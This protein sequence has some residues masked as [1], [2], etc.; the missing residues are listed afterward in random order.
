MNII[1]V[2]AGRV[3]Y[4]V[5]EVLSSS[6][7]IM[8]VERDAAKAEVVKNQLNISVL[9]DDGA[10]PKVLRNA[11]SRHKADTV[12]ATTAADD[13]NL[14]IC[15]MCKRIDPGIKT[16]ARVRNPDY[17]IET[18]ADGKEGVDQLIKPELTSADKIA[19]LALLENAIDYESIE[20]LNLSIAIF[21]VTKHNPG[22]E[23]RVPLTLDIPANTGIVAIYRGDQVITDV[24]TTELHLGDRIFVLGDYGG[25]EA[26]NEMMGVRR[27][28]KEFVILG[29]GIT[30]AHV[31]GILESKKRYVKLIEPDP[32]RCKKLVRDFSSVIVVNG[33]IV[34]PH[35]LKNENIGRADAVIALSH[36]DETNLLACH[37]AI[38]LGSPK[39]IA[40]YS[41]MDYEDIFE[42]T[43]IRTVIGYHRVVANEITKTM[44]SD[45][46]SVLRMKNPEE[47][48]FTS[49][50]GMRSKLLGAR[51]GDV[52]L[53]PGVRIACIVRDGSPVFPKL[54]TQFLDGDKLLVYAHGANMAKLGKILGNKMDLGV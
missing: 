48:F 15:M 7:D 53:P 14:F 40:R 22:V 18:S 47:V 17:Y 51:L 42:F 8:M 25:L 19:T 1:V 6:H 50:V 41:L 38:K 52:G 13:E 49:D 16:I 44:V 45:E 29:G 43:G 35:L 23:N 26:F 3:G 28:A 33:D 31:A 5:A 46:E 20:S 21:E 9:H 11:I 34:D 39:I 2:G 12:I 36:K 10:N 24:E 30:G 4:T 27:R 37:M 32:E 54:D